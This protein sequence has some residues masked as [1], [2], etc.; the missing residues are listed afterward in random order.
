R[1]EQPQCG[2]GV[3]TW[4]SRSTNGG[5]SFA[6]SARLSDA[7]VDLAALRLAYHNSPW[8]VGDNLA[9]ETVGDEVQAFWAEGVFSQTEGQLY[10]DGEIWSAI[11]TDDTPTSTLVAG[12]WAEPRNEVVRLRWQ[13]R[14]TSR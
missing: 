7:T 3:Q 2:A 8:W 1:R 4:W 14:E 10:P 13:M 12:F 11:I 9:L 5:K 6:P